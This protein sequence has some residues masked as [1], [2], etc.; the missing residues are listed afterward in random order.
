MVSPSSDELPPEL[1]HQARSELA[2]ARRALDG[3]DLR[4]VRGKDIFEVFDRQLDFAAR[5]ANGV[6]VVDV[7]GY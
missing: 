6:T 2:V 5:S 4:T 7:P 3:A 1:V